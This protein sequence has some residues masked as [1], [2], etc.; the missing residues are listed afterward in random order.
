MQ[1]GERLTEIVSGARECVVQPLAG[2]GHFAPQ[3]LKL[4]PEISHLP[5]SRARANPR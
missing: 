3:G 5:S 4:R 2:C 1:R